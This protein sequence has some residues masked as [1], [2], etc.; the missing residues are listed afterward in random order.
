MFNMRKGQRYR[1]QNSECRAEIEVTKDSIEGASNPRCSCGAEMKKAYTK[2]VLR[3][4]DR[5]NAALK[6]LFKNA[7]S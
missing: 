4:L 5:D 3:M 1:C 6:E 7:A 2:P